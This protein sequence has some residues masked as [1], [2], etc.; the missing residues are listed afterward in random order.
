MPVY[1]VQ[2]LE[3]LTAESFAP[4]QFYLRLIGAFGMMALG[5]AAVGVYGLTSFNVAQRTHELGIRLAL[6][7]LP[8]GPLQQ[9]AWEGMRLTLAGLVLGV[10]C[11]LLLTRLICGLLYEVAPTDSTTLLV[12]SDCCFFARW[13]R[14]TSRR[15]ALCESIVWLPFATN[16]GGDE[17]RWPR[18][19]AS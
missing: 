19:W 5:L 3:R 1:D 10:A 16:E 11:A 13:R 9:I 18:F 6:G 12:A 14:V 17:K 7:T 4:N 15:G 2:T 8:G